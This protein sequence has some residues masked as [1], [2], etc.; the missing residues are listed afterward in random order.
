MAPEE[1]ARRADRAQQ[2]L[3]NEIYVEA[4]QSIRERIWSQLALVELPEE[5][6]ARLNALAVALES[7]NKY[8]KVVLENGKVAADNIER[9]KKFGERVRERIS[10]PT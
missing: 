5:K 10:W 3:G 4:Y 6:R 7:V 1:E 2:V 9:N 8:M